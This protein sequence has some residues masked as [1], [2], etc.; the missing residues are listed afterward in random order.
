MQAIDRGEIKVGLCLGGNLFGS[1]PDAAWSTRVMG[2]L[3]H[4]AYM[5]T[6]LNTG[7]AW[8]TG[9]ETVIL[10]VAVRDEE[11]QPTTQ[12]SMFSY[13]RLSEGGKPR[14]PNTRSEDRH[15]RRSGRTGRRRSLADGL[16]E[17]AK[18]RRPS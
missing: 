5:S 1:G 4:V 8:G 9:K 18:P 16:E 7:H 15:P 13:V 3:D 17:A 2:K 12:E 14:H 6:T 10:P 11:E